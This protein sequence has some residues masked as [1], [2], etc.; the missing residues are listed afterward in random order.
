MVGTRARSSARLS[1]DSANEYTLFI[2]S[3]ERAEP[4]PSEAAIRLV[5]T[6]APTASAASA[7]RS[8][9]RPRPL[10]DEPRAVRA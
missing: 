9:Q 7:A 10:A 6:S 1:G 8:A 2:D 4:L 5:R 3:T